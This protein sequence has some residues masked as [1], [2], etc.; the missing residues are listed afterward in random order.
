VARVVTL[1]AVL[2]CAVGVVL[3]SGASAFSK[4]I[5]GQVT[6]NG[7]NQFPMYQKLGVKIIEYDLP[8]NVAAPT[9]PANPTN[10]ADPAYQWPADVAQVIQVA[11]QYHMQVL[12]QILNAPAWEDGGNSGNGWAPLHAADFAAFAK[13]AARE[14]PTVHLWMVWGEPDKAGNFMPEEP[15]TPGVKLTAAQKAAP[16][17]YAED[18]DAAYAALKSVSRKNLVIGGNTYTTGEIDP[19]QWIENMK[20]PNGKPP[21]M[22]MYGHNPFSY[23]PP[24]FSDPPSAFDQV[25]FS[26]LHE[27][28]RWIQKYFH[29]TLP[30]F[31]SEWTIP[32]QADD[33]FNFYV[34]PNTAARWI[35]DAMHLCRH[36]KEIYALGWVNVYDDLP[37]TSGGLLYEN[38][39]PKPGFYAFEN[40]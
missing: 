15:A 9:Q 23:Q 37:M 20:L 29:K 39:T 36:W 11:A 16:E 10:P 8:W 40:G 38:G 24:S 4:A 17:R 6:R 33:T 14:Y 19:L 13:A 35:T 1:A 27:L 28:E 5:W 32:T 31:L 25:Q 34:D 7:V 12:L 26:D 18:L 30:L 3:P 22:D 21:R 2:A